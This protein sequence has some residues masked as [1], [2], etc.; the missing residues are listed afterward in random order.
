MS[1]PLR[2]QVR[3]MTVEEFAELPDDGKR[4]E[5][6]R[7]VVREMSPTNQDHGEVG[8]QITYLLRRWTKRRRA[9]RVRIETG[10]VLARNPDTLRGPDV[11]FVRYARDGDSDGPWVKGGPTSPSRSARRAIANARLTSAL[12][13]TCAPA[14][15]SSGSL[16][17]ASASS[18]SA[19]PAAKT[20]R[21]RR[22]TTWRAV[23]CCQASASRCARS[24][25]IWTRAGD[26][27]MN[28]AL[29]TK[30]GIDRTTTDFWREV[31]ERNPG[32]STCGEGPLWFEA[33]EPRR[34][35]P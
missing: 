28:S 16:T 34:G 1:T 12:P 25:R 35:N 18:S 9:G 29:S 13:T 31:G 24:S 19:R 23:T 11:S 20:A 10:H 7:G 33:R 17:H 27:P 8:S 26:T 6:V 21:S 4:Y 3:L 30:T 32:L 5:L 14:P 15:C 22:P 2:A